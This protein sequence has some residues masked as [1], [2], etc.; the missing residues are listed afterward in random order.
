MVLVDLTLVVFIGL[1]AFMG[2]R[3]GLIHESVTLIGL[4]AGLL[5]AGQSY[6]RF[7]VLL[8]PWLKTRG[9]ANLGAF[10]VLLAAIWLVVL[11]LGAL[12]RGMLEGLRL[13]W[14]D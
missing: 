11:A 2:L 1:L 5:I 12:F 8:L 7:G 3:S 14:I 6:E 9:M 4:V 13:G 10:I